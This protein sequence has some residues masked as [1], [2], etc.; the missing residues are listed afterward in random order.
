MSLPIKQIL[1]TI[2]LISQCVRDLI[3][4]LTFFCMFFFPYHPCKLLNE[5]CMCVSMRECVGRSYDIFWPC[6]FF[7]DSHIGELIKKI[8][9]LF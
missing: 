7:G 2:D 1:F 4:Q 6:V 5:D 3:T 8:F 9:H